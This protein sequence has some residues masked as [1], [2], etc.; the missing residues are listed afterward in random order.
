MI[1][2]WG[3][4]MGGWGYGPSVGNGGFWWMGLMGMAF[5]LIFWVA[6]IALGIYLFKRIGLSRMTVGSSGRPDAF[7]ILKERYARGEID[8][9]EYQ[10]R[11]QDLQ[12]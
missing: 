11:K 1:G 5:Q 9:D 4:M 2:G 3:N 10:R 7:D 8:A 12:K 6:I